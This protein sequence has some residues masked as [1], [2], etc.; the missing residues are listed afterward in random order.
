VPR[1]LADTSIWA[2]A[3]KPQRPD[4]KAK[5]VQRLAADEVVTCVPVA[6]EVMHGPQTSSKYREQFEALLDPLDW[7]SLTETASW[8]ALE[9][10]QLLAAQ[11]DGAHRRPTIDL[12]IA[13]IAEEHPDIVM[14]AFDNDYAVIAG[15]TGQAVEVEESTGPG[16]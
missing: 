5:L 7:L 4:I 16:R 1:Y 9:V 11:S 2:W 3:N 6:L 15:V 8:R 14:W 13:A 12:L 10:Q